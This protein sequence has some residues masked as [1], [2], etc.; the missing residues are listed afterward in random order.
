VAVDACNVDARSNQMKPN[1]TNTVPSSTHHTSANGKESDEESY[2]YNSYSYTCITCLQPS[3]LLYKQYSN[4]KN[5]KL[6]TCTKC[7]H[8]VDPYI[9]RELLLVIMDMMLLRTAAYR[10]LFFNRS[11]ALYERGGPERYGA[12][13]SGERNSSARTSSHTVAVTGMYSLKNVLL[14]VLACIMLRIALKLQGLPDGPVPANMKNFQQQLCPLIY[15]SLLEFASQW[16]GTM[17]MAYAC[18]HA[19]TRKLAK[20]SVNSNTR[21]RAIN[22]SSLPIF[23]WNQLHMSIIIP[24]LF[25]IVTLLVH[26]YENSFMV[27]GLGSL[28]VPCFGYLAVHTIMERWLYQCNLMAND[29]NGAK[30]SEGKNVNASF[31]SIWPFL[32]G[33]VLE[34]LVSMWVSKDGLVRQAINFLANPH[35]EYE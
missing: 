4:A 28:F 9:E 22:A 18:L 30:D 11:H 1:T 31:T 3:P 15:T 2:L 26:V 21:G 33:L 7:C 27:R 29:A 34:L 20:T 24:Q 16:G 23:F 17:A 32:V 5:I 25:H 6:Q 10:H 12:R 13:G 35:G 19:R 14:G 8:D